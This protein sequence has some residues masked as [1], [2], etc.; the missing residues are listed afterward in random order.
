MTDL[1]SRHIHELMLLPYETEWVEHKHNNNEPDKIGETISAISNSAALKGKSK[2]YIFWGI[3][4]ASHKVVGT[5]FS[6]RQQKIGN[7]ALENWLLTRLEPRINIQ[8]HEVTVEEKP[9]VVFEI[10]AASNVPVR[11]S[12]IDYIRIG[13]YK[14]KLR[15]HPEK[16]RALWQMFDKI[17][18]E[19]KLAIENTSEDEV[20]SLIDYPNYFQL[21]QQ[22]LPDNRAGILQR[23][24]S[25]EI[26]ILSTTKTYNITNM[27]ALLFARNLEEFKHLARKALRVIFYH[28]N[29]RVETIKE[30]KGSK[31]YA[32]GFKEMIDYING[33]LPQNEQLGHAFRKEVRM[34]PE[35]A[36]RE[37]VAN[38]LIHQD[39]TITGAGPVIEIF[40]D[41]MEISNPGLPLIDTLRFI[42]EPP[43]SRNEG[44]ASL[45]RRMNIC[46][47]RGSGIDKVI[48]Y[49]EFY[50][51]RA[52]DFRVTQNSTITI[53]YGPQQFAK[54]TREERIR[55][56]YQHACL[57]H[58]S[59]KRMSNASLR[60]RL[61][62]K[63]SNYPTA[64]KI[65]RDAID[66][67]L[68]KQYGNNTQ[69][70]KDATYV[71]FWA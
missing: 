67:N 9:I 38:A 1:Q 65:I 36:V 59:D 66:A 24:V 18:F 12:G 27:G 37:L 43:R 49:V 25:E 45:M 62:I 69:S 23:L 5:S 22:P 3:E 46:E 26:I 63:E 35:I 71:P 30:H 16:E 34:Y 41:R 68:I 17:P 70:R 31:G 21:M 14:K 19:K 50:Q 52:P 29:N 54:M 56:C 6:P 57:C 10:D 44:L 8:I 39:F 28:E 7:E 47:E 51:L 42:D 61:G 58:V 48:F 32:I 64:S 40:A 20:L 2:G 33:Q 55:A 4:D 13:S 60:K 11:F 53:L 15:E